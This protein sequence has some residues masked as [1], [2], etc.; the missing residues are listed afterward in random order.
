MEQKIMDILLVISVD[1]KDLKKGQKR[2]E[3]KVEKLE[4]NQKRLEENQ[5]KLEARQAKLEEAQVR[6]ETRQ[7]KLEEN[8]EKLEVR[9]TKLEEAQ[10]RLEGRQDKL[11]GICQISNN[12]ITRILEVQ[13]EIKKQLIEKLEKNEQKNEIEHL[14][15]RNR[16]EVAEKKQKLMLYK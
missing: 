2:L 15:F 8:Q 14:E 12:N 7:A 5:A 4:A 10:A 13:L 11:Q 6:L 1:V 3:D 16:I 9:Q